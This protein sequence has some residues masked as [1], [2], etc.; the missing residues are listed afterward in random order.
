MIQYRVFPV[1]DSAPR[2]ITGPPTIIECADDRAAMEYARQIAD[3]RPV[4][5][6]DQSRFI[7]FVTRT[8]KVM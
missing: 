8:G 3:G 2:Q 7:G 1:D 4:E 5:V 6:W